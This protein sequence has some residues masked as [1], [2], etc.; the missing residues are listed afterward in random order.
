MQREEKAP[1]KISTFM[2]KNAFPCAEIWRETRGRKKKYFFDQIEPG[3]VLYFSVAVQKAR[4]IQTA[5]KR[6]ARKEK[7]KIEIQNH[8][9]YLLIKKNR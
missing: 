6:A 4:N 9:T 8:G 3:K 7:V 5:M 2:L 1:E